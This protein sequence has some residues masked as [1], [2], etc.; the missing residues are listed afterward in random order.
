[1]LDKDDLDKV[2]TL[3]KCKD[4]WFSF[5]N[6]LPSKNELSSYYNYVYEVPLYQQIKIKKKFLKI[7]NLLKKGFNY[8]LENKNILDIGASHWFLL[9]LFKNYWANVYG[10]EISKYACDNAKKMF[11]IDIENS[12]FLES[13]FYKKSDFFDIVTMLDVLEHL[14][15]Q[16]EI[17]Q[18]IYKVLKKWGK[19]I[20]TVPNLNSLE[21]RLYRKYWEWFSPPAHLIYYTP[22][23]LRKML[24][25]HGFKVSHIETYQW[26]SVG[27]LL[28]QWYLALR[29]FIFYSLKYVYWKEK[30]FKIREQIRK[31]IK[32]NTQINGEEFV[33]H[34]KFIYFITEILS[35]PFIPLSKIRYKLWFWPTILAIAEKK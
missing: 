23:T 28:Y 24:N 11:G 15:N 1:M 4:C 13:S 22:E 34:D 5:I 2:Y 9:N 19:F 26:D 25:K 18:G 16:N 20:L 33:W 29:Q 12:D 14:A 27:N 21:F 32:E 31:K 17:L 30:L 35:W 7:Y 3:V 8:S 10:V 6:P